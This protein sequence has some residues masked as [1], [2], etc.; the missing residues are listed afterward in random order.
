MKKEYKI[1]LLIILVGYILRVLPYLLGYPIPITDDSLRDFQHVQYL[2][3]NNRINL[4]THY[5]TFPVLHL[6]IFGI[7]KM[8]FDP[9]KAFLFVPQV[10]ATLGIFF[11]FLFLKKYFPIRKSLFAC[12]F[13]AVFGPHIYWS[14]QPVR[15]TIGL[16]FFP[17]IIYLFDKE[18]TNNKILTKI[19]LLL[20]FILIILTHPW[21]TIMTIGFL[22]FAALFF[23]KDKLSYPLSL[24]AIFSI[25][26]LSYWRL[27][28]PYIFELISKPPD[29]IFQSLIALFVFIGVIF[30]LRRFD[31][32]KL[33][34]AP[35]LIVSIAVILLFPLVLRLFIV[36]AYP[37]QI[38]ISFVLFVALI[39][40]GFFYNRAENMNNLFKVNLF[41]AVFF[42]VTYIYVLNKLDTAYFLDP[43]RTVEFAIFPS[44]IAAS[45]GFF[46]VGEKLKAKYFLPFLI[47]ILTFL[48]TLI[49]PPI[50]IYKNNFENTP[51]Y[52]IR[53]DI[54]YIPKEGFKLLDWAHAHGYSVLAN[55][56]VINA[57]QQIHYPRKGKELLLLTKG[58]YKISKLYSGYIK[59]KILGIPDPQNLIE[60]S[61]GSKR[62]YS[63]KWG[64]L[65]EI[66]NTNLP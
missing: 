32:N 14:S 34:N 56:Y 58:D 45:F 27:F 4:S 35:A 17:L 18:L 39:L 24:I 37:P 22:L 65:Y 42:I 21:S 11:F 51:F 44:S 55:S 30:F 53:S 12:F 31:L 23:Y 46:W 25:L 19:L 33:K 9:M 20:S 29:F 41:Y 48:G 38:I 40:V 5:G 26:A 66:A 60:K 13:I 8:G 2:I 63:N 47:V 7:S 49:Y 36:F 16:F 28:F 52:D 57:Y 50:F 61:N 6:V 59:H 64:A 62:V 43:I 1:I 10:F 3:E 15:E 54:R